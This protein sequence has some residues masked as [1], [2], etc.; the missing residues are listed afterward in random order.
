[1]KELMNIDCRDCHYCAQDPDGLWCA[2]SL[3][4]DPDSR[5][6]GRSITYA[7]TLEFCG[8]T[9]KLFEIASPEMLAARGRAP[10]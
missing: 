2:K 4:V 10:K 9:A 8:P 5:P 3:E 1:M 7:R 6:F